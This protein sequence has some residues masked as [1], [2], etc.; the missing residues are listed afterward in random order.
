MIAFIIPILGSHYLWGEDLIAS[1]NF[2]IA[3]YVL[4]L[5]VN[6][7]INSFAHIWGMRPYDE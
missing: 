3:R 1:M 5:H 6:W 2:N 4:G 7:S